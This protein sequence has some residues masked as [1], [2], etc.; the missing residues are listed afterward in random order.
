MSHIQNG[1]KKK[2]KTLLELFSLPCELEK[3]LWLLKSEKV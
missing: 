1:E 2:R 3:E